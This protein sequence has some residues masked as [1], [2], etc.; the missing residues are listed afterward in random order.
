[1]LFTRLICKILMSLIPIN[2]T[3][4]CVSYCS[5]S[6]IFI[7]LVYVYVFIFSYI[8]VPLHSIFL[9]YYIFSGFCNRLDLWNE[10]TIQ[11]SIRA[12]RA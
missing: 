4:A 3:H 2:Y 1:M 10:N 5:S 7:D 11:Y 6:V 12:E 9:T 8:F